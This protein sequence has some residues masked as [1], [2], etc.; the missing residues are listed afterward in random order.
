MGNGHYATVVFPMALPALYTYIIPED[1]RTSI[2]PGSRVEVALRN[3]VYSAIVYALHT[4]APEGLKARSVLSV[5]DE[6]PLVSQTQL[7]LWTWMARYYCCTLGEVMD[8]GLPSGL[9][10]HS[11]SLFVL[12]PDH[13]VQ[14]EDLTNE[15]Y[16]IAE[17]LFLRNEL[18]LDHIRDIL[19]KKS[20]YPVLKALM[21][22]NLLTVKEQLTEKFKPKTVKTLR[23]AEKYLGDDGMHQ[24]FD[25]IRKSD[26]QTKVLAAWIDLAEANK[27]ITSHELTDASGAPAS[28]VQALI[29]K[30][31]FVSSSKTVSRLGGNEIETETLPDLN[32]EQARALVE[33]RASFENKIPVLLHG[34]TGSGKTRIYQELIRDTLSAGKQVLYLLPEIALT[35]QIVDRL[36]ESFGND[37]L[38]YHSKMPDHDRVEVWQEAMKGNKLVLSARSGIFLPFVNLGLIIVDEEHDASYKQDAPNPHYNARD[39]ALYMAHRQGCAIVLGS[40][41]PSLESAYNALQGKITLVE[42]RCRFGNVHMPGIDIVDLAYE[43]KT[44]RFKPVLSVPLQKAMKDVLEKGRQVILFQNRRGFVPT[45]QCRDCGWTA[46]CVN[47]DV[48]LTYH[49]FVNEL[50]CHY[51]SHKQKNPPH[52]PECGGADLGEIGLGTEKIEHVVR[53]YFPE[54]RVSRLDLDTTRTKSAQ[55][56]IIGAFSR[57]DID[58]LVGTQMV[59]KGFDFDHVALV[60]VIDADALIRFPDFRAVERT[61][62]LIT[63]VSGRAGRRAEQGRV[64]IQ[65]YAAQHPV[66]Q[67]IIHHNYAAFLKRELSERKQF[68]FPPFNRLIE[69]EIKHTSLEKAVLASNEF[70]HILRNTIGNRVKGP[71]TPSISRIRNQ[72]IRLIVLKLEKDD[73]LIYQTKKLIMQTKEAFGKNKDFQS[74]RIRVDV[75]PY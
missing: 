59:T 17:A 41:T 44:H 35:S 34:V 4:D 30:G 8:A 1:L 20:V 50:S 39:V 11:E 49:K 69:L 51:C 58:V 26:V 2:F 24:A 13:D 37:I 66:I 5:I 12:N 75:D 15:E 22:K 29:K 25:R 9:K 56:K 62:Q 63:Q 57:G 6:V 68:W 54:A 21:Q 40:A 7:E 36:Y 71:I 48:S 43:R 33:I 74:V 28:A 32:D 65:T 16:L 19:Q 27:A 18:N 55:D 38:L 42:L 70:A 45:I 52:C 31:I 53:Q 67:E 47:C 23:L 61:F 3:K 64:L 60:G 72:Y 14:D 46:R 10:L 73:K